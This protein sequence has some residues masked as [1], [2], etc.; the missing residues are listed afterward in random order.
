MGR[1]RREVKKI[2]RFRDEDVLRCRRRH[3]RRR[4][5]RKSRRRFGFAL[6]RVGRPSFFYVTPPPQSGET[7]KKADD[8]NDFLC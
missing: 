7:H 8:K 2:R 5:S 4:K 3:R 6:S 1:R